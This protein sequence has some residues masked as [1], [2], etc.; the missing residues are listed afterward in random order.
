MA[1]ILIIE[2]DEVLALMYATRLMSEGHDVTIERDGESGLARAR[3]LKPDII[4]LDLMLPGLSGHSVLS[5]LRQPQGLP[6]TPV[7]VLSNLASPSEE[8]EAI[9]KGATKFLLKTRVTPSEVL[10]TITSLLH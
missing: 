3:E 1:K 4:L 10:A 7:I 6:T 8:Q 2:D 5:E 9:N